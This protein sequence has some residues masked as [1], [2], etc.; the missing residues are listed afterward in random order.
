MATKFD[1]DLHDARGAIHEAREA[2]HDAAQDLWDA[3][4]DAAIKEKAH[5]VAHRV[6]E[7]LTGG[8]ESRGYMT[9]Y[10]QELQHNPLRTKMFT[11]GVLSALQELFASILAGDKS[12]HGN[13]VNTRMPKMAMYGA[14]VSAPLGHLLIGI[15]QRMFK[16]RTTIKAKI[17]QILVSNLI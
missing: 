8:P 10:L 1:N 5:E 14:F 11:S 16:G 3:T 13:Y 17:W 15:L 4:S 6:G 9:I 2:L 7:R 12:R